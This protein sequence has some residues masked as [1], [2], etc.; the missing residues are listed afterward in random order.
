[1]G[2]GVLGFDVYIDRQGDAEG[3]YTLLTLDVNQPDSRWAN[4]GWQRPDDP[5]WRRYTSTST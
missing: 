5:M 1:M 3:N 2:V 4:S